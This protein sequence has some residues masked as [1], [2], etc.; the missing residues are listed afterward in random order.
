[1]PFNVDNI[2]TNHE[3]LSTSPP[4][5]LAVNGRGSDET[6]P[7]NE[8]E[9]ATFDGIEK[10][11]A[12][13]KHMSNHYSCRYFTGRDRRRGGRHPLQTQARRHHLRLR[14]SPLGFKYDS[15]SVLLRYRGLN[16]GDAPIFAGEIGARETT[17]MNVSVTIFGDRL[18]TSSQF[19]SDVISVIHGG[20]D[21]RAREKGGGVLEIQHFSAE[22]FG[23]GVD[24]GQLVGEIL[25]ENRL[26]YSHAD[27]SDAD[28]GD[29]GVTLGRR[30]RRRVL[31]GLELF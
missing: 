2:A 25:H 21:L 9:E 8:Y 27:I 4:P 3:G 17:S 5:E 20:L 15:T 31:Y 23:L 13:K 26:R 29:F 19:F 14:H 24:E 10:V 6:N 1:M 28:D 22:L 12:R 18:L 11:V 7:S 16:I 30:R